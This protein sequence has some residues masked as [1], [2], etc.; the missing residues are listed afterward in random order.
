M[1]KRKL[2]KIKTKAQ[3]KISKKLFGNK[4]FSFICGDCGLET[5]APLWN[6][7]KTKDGKIIC[8][9]CEEKRIRS[10]L[11]KSENENEDN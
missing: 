5:I 9:A 6:M 1:K 11:G 7:R 10:Q 4:K 2:K 8:L 3:V